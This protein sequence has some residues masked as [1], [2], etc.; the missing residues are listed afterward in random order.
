MQQE[1]NLAIEETVEVE[2]P[3]EEK[4]EESV[5]IVEEN[6]EKSQPEQEEKN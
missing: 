4:K 3:A 6:A 2:L 1:E 5:E